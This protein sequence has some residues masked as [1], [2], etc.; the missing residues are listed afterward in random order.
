MT[1]IDDIFKN[2]NKK[3]Q[4]FQKLT[5]FF[6]KSLLYDLDASNYLLNRGLTK[7]TI[8]TFSIGY[9][10]S[11]SSL[12][13]FI[14]K[15]N[16]DIVDLEE[17][18][19]LTKNEDG[20]YY[21]KFV[22]RIIFPV[23]DLKGNVIAFS[24]RVYKKDDNR[25]KYITS[26]LSEV[27][28]KSLSLYGFYQSLQNIIKYKAVFIVEGNIDV[29]MCYQEGIKITVGPFGTSF[30][31]EHFLLL[32]QFADTFIFCLDND[33][34]GKKSEERIRKMLENE[35][36]TKIGYLHLEGVKDPD[37]F[38]QNYGITPL[39]NTI[40]EMKNELQGIV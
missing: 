17:L 11:A 30:M 5:K 2:Y 19:V 1:I 29:N 13:Q 15:E 8:E 31:E 39:V 22:R 12:Q 7:S 16:I 23:F 26:N 14:E 27:F 28:Q 25:S 34:G 21:D 9:D 20:S 37:E 6:N 36:D 10:K 3:L 24:G 4:V 18:G 38:I 32:K 40:I 33:E 35:T